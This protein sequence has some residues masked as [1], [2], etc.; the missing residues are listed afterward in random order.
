[1]VVELRDGTVI[2][3]AHM[4]GA[5]NGGG[6]LQFWIIGMTEGVEP[7]E[8]IDQDAIRLIDFGD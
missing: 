8:W 5:G 1:M 7:D 2:E 6:G 4:R 3:D